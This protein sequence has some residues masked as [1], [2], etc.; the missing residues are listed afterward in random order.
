VQAHERD[1][2]VVADTL[3]VGLTRPAMAFGVTY[4]ALLFNGVVS[5][6]SFLLTR[7]LLCL[8]LCAPLHVLFWIACLTEPRCFELWALAAQ[9][10][11]RHL[12][13]NRRYWGLD[14]A[15]PLATKPVG[16]RAVWL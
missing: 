10:R 4:S 16:L 15:G 6:E 14:S 8:A 1:T 3:F 13:A 12:L 2:G 5:V 9:T 7:N 11:L